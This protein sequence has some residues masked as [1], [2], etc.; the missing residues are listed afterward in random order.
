MQATLV[1]IENKKYRLIAE[2]DYKRL[3][4]DLKDVKKVAK[5]HSEKGME[6]KAFFKIADEQMK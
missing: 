4:N 1:K 2:E 3:L 5:R 6:A